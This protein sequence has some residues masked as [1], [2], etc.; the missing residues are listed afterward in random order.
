MSKNIQLMRDFIDKNNLSTRLLVSRVQSFDQENN[1]AFVKYWQKTGLPDDAFVRSFHNYN[2]MIDLYESVSKPEINPCLV[3]WAR[4]NIGL[5][6]QA[7]VCFNELFKE[8]LDPSVILG[9]LN[10]QSI[11]EIWQGDRLNQIRQA[12]LTGNYTLNKLNDLPCK[13]CSSCQSMN[14]KNQTSEY[15]LS[16]VGNES[17]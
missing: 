8:H 9:D 1:E 13:N 3:H 12:E 11:K 7:V 16:F 15:Q 2:E 6:G 4:F 17:C 10:D 5:K 14:I